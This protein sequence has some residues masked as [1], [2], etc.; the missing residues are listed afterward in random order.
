V[1]PRETRAASLGTE[2]GFSQGMVRL[3]TLVFTLSALAIPNAALARKPLSA[4]VLVPVLVKPT[5]VMR[6]D[7]PVPHSSTCG[8]CG[9]GIP[10]ARVGHNLLLGA[11]GASDRLRLYLRRDFRQLSVDVGTNSALVGYGF[12][13]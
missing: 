4:P 6:L 9:S 11:D 2:L 10:D 12:R 3:R 5:T 8:I 1:Q 13:F 7:L